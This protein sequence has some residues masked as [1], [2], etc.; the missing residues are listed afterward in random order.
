MLL[1]RN[2]VSTNTARSVEIPPAGWQRGEISLTHPAIYTVDI[3]GSSVKST[4]YLD[5]FQHL[6]CMEL[7]TYTFL[8]INDVIL[9]Y[10]I[11]FTFVITSYGHFEQ[12]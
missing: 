7:Y 1:V 10:R 6:E 4:L 3:R 9:K 12:I 11:N 5:L 8:C 2:D